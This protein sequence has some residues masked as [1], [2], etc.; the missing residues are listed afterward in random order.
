MNLT[1]ASSGIILRNYRKRDYL[2]NYF[3]EGKG[4][5]GENFILEI[6]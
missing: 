2:S 3:G 6:S 5:R 1:I 4:I